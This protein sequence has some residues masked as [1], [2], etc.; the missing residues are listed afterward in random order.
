MGGPVERRD[1]MSKYWLIGIAVV[2]VAVALILKAMGVSPWIC[3]PCILVA[4]IIG[5]IGIFKN[6]NNEVD[7]PNA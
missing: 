4:A 5:V 2:L 1:E 7:P 6:D 3:A